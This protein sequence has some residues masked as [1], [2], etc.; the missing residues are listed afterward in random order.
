MSVQEHVFIRTGLPPDEVAKRVASALSMHV[1]TGKNGGIFLSRPAQADKEKQI[2][3]EV[4]G[5]YLADPQA[6]GDDA[7]LLDYYEIIWDLGYTG[8]DRATQLNEA[9]LLFNEFASAALWPAA[10]VAGLVVLVAAWDPL[11]GLTWFPPGTSP[12]ADQRA[13]WERYVRGGSHG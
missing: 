7:S 11:A 3:G 9:R 2:G 8:R 4:T 5:N 12:D 1:L 6:T 13:L 10:L